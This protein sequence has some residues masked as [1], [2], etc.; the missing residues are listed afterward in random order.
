MT[1]RNVVMN[2]ANTLKTANA[3]AMM[4]TAITKEVGSMMNKIQEVM[5]CVEELSTKLG[6]PITSKDY[7]IDDLGC[8]HEP[9]GLPKGKCGVYLFFYNGEALKIGKVN[10]RSPDRFKYQHYGFNAESTLAKSLVADNGFTSLGVDDS[11]VG[12]WIKEHM[13]RVDIVIN[14]ECGD[15]VTM[16]VESIMLYTFR[17][18]YEGFLHRKGKNNQ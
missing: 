8:P 9:K 2:A 1:G 15:A 14:G 18:C 4:K 11:N 16:L 12:S 5:K 7:Y 3:T 17:P 10:D 13:H 6:Y